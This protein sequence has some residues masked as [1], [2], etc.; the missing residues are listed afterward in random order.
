[1]ENMKNCGDMA[2][3]N[4]WVYFCMNYPYDFIEQI[5]GGTGMVRHF[6][7]KFEEYYKFVGSTGVMNKF[8]CNLSKGYQRQLLEWVL[9]NY[10]DEQKL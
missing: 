10:N 2:A 6:T 3:I 9:K 4:K 1:M 8:Y 7:A 5:W